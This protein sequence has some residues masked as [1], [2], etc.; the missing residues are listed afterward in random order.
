[1][2]APALKPFAGNVAL[3]QDQPLVSADGTA[4]IFLAVTNQPSISAFDCQALMKKVNAFRAQA[5]AGWEGGP[6]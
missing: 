2:I 5:S 6:L 1:M 4:R 3:E